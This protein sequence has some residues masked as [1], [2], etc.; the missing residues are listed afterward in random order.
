ME[1]RND[2]NLMTCA[3][4]MV[5][6]LICVTNLLNLEIVKKTT[7]EKPILKHIF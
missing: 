6:Y 7:C 1:N 3:K 4:L 5:E 2:R